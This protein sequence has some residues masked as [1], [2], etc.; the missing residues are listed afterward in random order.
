MDVVEG[1]HK[2]HGH[3]CICEGQ[4]EDLCNG[5]WFKEDPN[6][7]SR[8]AASLIMVVTLIMIINM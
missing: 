7:G 5:Q 1:D 6:S 8:M 4:E 2:I 3:F